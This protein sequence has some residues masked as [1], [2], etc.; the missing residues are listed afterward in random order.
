MPKDLHRANHIHAH[1]RLR[2]EPFITRLTHSL[3][4]L[5]KW[6]GRAVAFVI[7][8]GLGVLLRM[9][10]V[11]AVLVVRGFRGPKEKQ[12][13]LEDVE[14]ESIVFEVESKEALPRY[15]VRL[16]TDEEIDEERHLIKNLKEAGLI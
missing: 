4:A 15:P 16:R 7:G 2:D 13:Q 1:H 9:V 5:G 3:L 14:V 10:W 8:C 11:M 12:V 6:E